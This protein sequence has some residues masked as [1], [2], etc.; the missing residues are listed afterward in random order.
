MKLKIY[1]IDAFASKT[2]E[3]NPAAVCPLDSWIDDSLMQKIAAEN[4]LSETVFFVKEDEHYHIR[5][6]TTSS[7]ENLCGHATL[8]SAYVL[9]EILDYKKQEIIFHSKSG[10]LKVSKTDELYTLN[11][12]LNEVTKID[13]EDKFIDAFNIKPIE[14][15]KSM[16]YL[17]VF[18][19][20]EDIYNLVPNFEL[21]KQ[22]D[23]RGVI[24]TAKSSQYDFVCRFFDPDCGVPEDPVT[25]SAFTQ[26]VPYW[27]KVL[28][29]KE[30]KAKQVSRRGG[31][32]FAKFENERVYISGKAVKYLEGEIYV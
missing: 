32:V 22:F 11:F 24:V 12:P 26:L 6:F 25:G 13:L 15:H 2:F 1:Q 28:K 17:I 19:T 10:V 14:I 8:A 4:N 20:E 30:F 21:I 31:E 9:F 5:W 16:D 27:A 23:L 18:K 3:G 7:E 29:K